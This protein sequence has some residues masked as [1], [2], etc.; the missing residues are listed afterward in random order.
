MKLKDNYHLFAMMTI[1]FWSFAS[2]FTRL[3]LRFFTPLSLGFLRYFIASL[4]LIVFSLFVKIRIPDKNDIKWFVLAGFFGFFSYIIVFNIGCTTVSAAT[5]SLMLATVPVITTLLARILFKEKLRTIQYI[6]IVIEFTGIGVLTLMNGIFSVNIGLIWL[7]LASMALSFYN[8]LQRK[9]IKKYSPIQTAIISM[10]FGTILLCIFLPGSVVEIKN[11]PLTQI[12]YII[13]LGVF[14]SAIPY[15]TWTYAFS[16]TKDVSSVTNYMFI[17][18]FLTAILG[19]V[20]AQEIPD[21]PTIIGGIIIMTGLFIY[22]FSD[23]LK[24]F[25]ALFE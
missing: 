3:A 9:I 20:L 2:V 5:A 14:S 12:V 21:R 1:I 8:I 10:W 19:M 13:I 18:P 15:I 17:T 4:S 16:K 7:L 22:N 11:T 23:K 25:K 24:V 6:A